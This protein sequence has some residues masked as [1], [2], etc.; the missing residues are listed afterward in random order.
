MGAF[1]ELDGYLSEPFSI[2]YW[3]DDAIGHAQALVAGLS[4]DGWDA[5]ETAWRARPTQWQ[6]R[7]AQSLSHGPPLR[8]VPVLMV[9]VQD[10]DVAEAAADALRDFGS[11]ESPLDVPAHVIERLDRLGEARPGPVAMVVADLRRRVRSVC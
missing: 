8:A 2:D 4:A 10:D 7:A 1:A 9:D 5:L 6:A 3:S 11:P